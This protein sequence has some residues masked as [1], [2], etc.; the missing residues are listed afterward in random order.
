MLAC[1]RPCQGDGARTVATGL[2]T[3]AASSSAPV[4]IDPPA[5][6]GRLGSTHP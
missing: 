3:V 2:E 4:E 5:A 6:Q 1:G